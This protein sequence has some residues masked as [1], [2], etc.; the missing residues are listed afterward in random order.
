[1]SK[2]ITRTTVFVGAAIILGMVQT[3]QAGFFDQLKSAAEHAANSVVQHTVNHTANTATS[4]SSTRTPS[5]PS[6]SSS[7][8]SSRPTTASEQSAPRTRQARPASGI[9]DKLA[10]APSGGHGP[11]VSAVCPMPAN[12]KRSSQEALTY[13]SLWKRESAERFYHDNCRN[14]PYA[15]PDLGQ[16]CLCVKPKIARSMGSVAKVHEE[17]IKTIVAYY[18]IHGLHHYRMKGV[19]LGMSAAKAAEIL[20][21]AGYK[22]K[23]GVLDGFQKKANSSKLEI[24]LGTTKSPVTHVDTVTEINYTQIF[25]NHVR[26]DKNTLRQKLLAKYGRPAEDRSTPGADGQ[27]VFKYRD[28]DAQREFMTGFS[29]STPH[30]NEFVTM[31]SSKNFEH[32]LVQAEYEYHKAQKAAAERRKPKAQVQ[33]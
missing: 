29:Y 6:R 14:R 27:I 2:N 15:F 4:S 24:R 7:V 18:N 3:A 12:W 19:E 31:I 1:M 10:S 16:L 23:Q 21:Q 17:N 22:P 32:A 33:F 5:S 13:K 9:V 25:N 28:G 20:E 30:P 8:P 11:K 26:L